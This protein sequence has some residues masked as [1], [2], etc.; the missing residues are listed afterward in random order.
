MRTVLLASLRVHTRRYVAAAQAVVVGVSFVVTTAALTSAT[1]DGLT[2]GVSAPYAGADVV[3]T[4]LGGDDAARVVAA[5]DASGN[6]ASVLGWASERV[7]LDGR[8]LGDVDEVGHLASGDLRWQDLTDG[9]FPTRAGEAVVEDAVADRDGL[10]VGDRLEVGSGASAVEVR[11]VGLVDS[12]SML[13]RSDVY[14]TWADLAPFADSM[15]VDSVAWAGPTGPLAA[16]VPDASIQSADE[17]VAELTADVNRGVDVIALMLLLFASIA[18]FVSVLVIANTFSILFAQR[19]RDLALLR[20]VGATRRQV[21]ASVRAEAL[22]LGAVASVVGLAV[23]TGAGL[24]L[25]ALVD[26][27]F[28]DAGLGRASVSPA[29]YAGAA[30]TGLLVTLVASWLPT[31]RVT[32]V[33][34]LTALRPD[35]GVDARSGAGRVRIALGAVAVLGGVAL[36]A[37][38]VQAVSAPVM[39][40]GGVLSFT[41]LLLLLPLVVPA[42][43]SA[44][45]RATGRVLGTPGRLA[46]GNA[47]RNPRRTAATAASLLIGVTLTTAVLTGMA[48]ARGA[49]DDEMDHDHPLDAT[50]TAGR[51]PLP[52]NAA[53][54]VAAVDGVGDVLT[55]SGTRATVGGLGEV[56]VLATPDDLDPVARGT[57]TTLVPADGQVLLPYDLVDGDVPTRV[58]VTGS[59]GR[60][61]R[62]EV[63]LGDG[64][65]DAALVTRTT[66]DRLT[67]A[68]TDGAVWARADDDADADRLADDLDVAAASFGGSADG[69]FAE[70]AYVDLQL[71]VVTGAVVGLLG[72]SVVIALIGI[73]NTLGLSVLERG[74]ENALLRALGLTR[75][76]LRVMLGLEAVLLSVVATVL[77]TAIGTSFAWVGVQAMVRSVVPEAPLV[78][79]WGQLAAVVLVSAVAGL[80]A[81]GAA[82]CGSMSL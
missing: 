17:H 77:G 73:A 8:V 68:P 45:A 19:Q 3:A 10:A 23:G 6:G 4:G 28:P 79:P 27:R 74:R 50:V 29:W 61:V 41:G 14:L 53:D 18:L 9:A 39:V 21:L 59:D 67:D 26:A 16:A 62:L 69:G 15:Y 25:V 2:Q 64:W 70:R 57:A 34:P 58:S 33:D 80:L 20:C 65:G 30:V 43:I 12:P 22:V 48:S 60:T 42:L 76:Q 36:L 7:R 11:V 52:H 44:T 38:S 40:A 72:I 81:C 51:D 32:A 37:L 13:V 31:R 46:A 56:E 55:L 5:A 71:D 75:R 63:V 49:V 82:S 24:G 54:V 1:R 35:A 78:L 47:V 66:L